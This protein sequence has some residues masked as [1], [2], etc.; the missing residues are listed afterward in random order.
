MRALLSAALLAFL[1]FTAQALEPFNAEYTADFQ[2]MPV[3]GNTTRTLQQ[4]GNGVWKLQLSASMLVATL[5]EE[6]RL[7]LQ[8]GRLIPVSYRFERKGLGKNKSMAY[9]FDWQNLSVS[10]HY[11]EKPITLPLKKGLLDRASYQLALQQD[12][13][14]GKKNMS[15]EVLD[16]DK[17]STYEFRV[18]G[19][20]TVNTR[21]GNINA[22]HVERVRDSNASSRRTEL[23]FAPEWDYLLVQLMQRETDGKEY[24]ITLQKGRVGNKA[25][26]GQ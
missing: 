2:Q 17:I 9:D 7:Q 8:N 12:V 16:N 22:I 20:E 19:T 5:E 25:V 11:R 21:V 6:S 1:P 26:A 15:Y 23:W 4:D 3:S 14:S 13:A 10:G 18:L 24:Q